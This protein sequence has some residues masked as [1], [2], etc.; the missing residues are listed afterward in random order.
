M[1]LYQKINNQAMKAANARL[2]LNII[3]R[4][5]KITR[6]E[7]VD[8]TGLTGGTITNLTRSLIRDNYVLESGM[9]ESIG[10]R[11]PVYLEINKKAGYM[12][13]LE[14]EV[15]GITCV[16]SDFQGNLLEHKTVPVCRTDASNK[17]IGQMEDILYTCL[18]E[19]GINMGRMLGLGL[20]MPGPTDYLHGVLINP[21][22][23]PNLTNIPLRHILEDCFGVPVYI[24]KETSCALLSEYWFGDH[25]GCRRVFGLKA[26]ITGIGG[27]LVIDGDVFQ[28]SE[29]E[30]MDIGHTIVQLDGRACSCGNFG[31][32]EAHADATAA[33]AYVYERA[34]RRITV[35]ELIRGVEENEHDCVE[36]VKTCAFFLSL[37]LCNI[38]SLLNP[39]CFY[40]GGV[41]IERCPLLFEKTV[42]YM[43]RRSYPALVRKVG[44]KP[45][46]FGN[47]SAAIGGLALVY[48]AIS[49]KLF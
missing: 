45:F 8:E 16:L 36:A 7:L 10:G 22:N 2:V 3:R 39:E 48:N 42:E 46:I 15:S 37:A 27:A 33:C 1:P 44:K 41:F 21:P 32:L 13:G 38:A 43:N 19:I 4:H 29:G 17:L 11:K 9:G 35:D 47:L 23:F 24:S 25:D 18:R 5:N 14:L 31:C 49:K 20:A 26:G 34:N 28:E 6:K 40:I 12:A 30:S